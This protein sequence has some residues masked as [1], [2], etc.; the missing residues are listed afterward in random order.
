MSHLRSLKMTLS[1]PDAINFPIPNW[2]RNE[3][4]LL[5]YLTCKCSQ[6][7][8]PKLN[9][10]YGHRNSFVSLT[11]SSFSSLK[12]HFRYRH[13]RATQMCRIHAASHVRSKQNQARTFVEMR[14]RIVKGITLS[15]TST[16][17][18]NR[19]HKPLMKSTHSYANYD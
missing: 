18:M 12:W 19:C 8:L 5:M 1:R 13:L 3:L 2:F 7:C 14:Y 10:K 15:Y 17:L 6:Q 4:P 9:F 11:S 16:V